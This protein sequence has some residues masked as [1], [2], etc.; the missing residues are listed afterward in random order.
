MAVTSLTIFTACTP[1]EESPVEEPPH[2]HAWGNW[3][4]AKQATCLETGERER[5]C[6]CGERERREIS[7]A[8][9]KVAWE[10]DGNGLTHHG[11]CSVCKEVFPEED[12]AYNTTESRDY[13]CTVCGAASVYN[14]KF[15]FSPDND[16]EGYRIAMDGR[17]SGLSTSRSLQCFRGNP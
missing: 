2:I 8:A 6:E 3:K 10:S 15:Q 5:L 17:F 14:G 4:I 12:C 7:I 11:T 1:A 13:F 9:H 16:N